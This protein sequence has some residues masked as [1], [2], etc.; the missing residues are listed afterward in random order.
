[1][2]GKSVF[3]YS[4]GG[5]LISIENA[6]DIRLTGLALE[7]EAKPMDGG[8]LVVAEQVKGFDLSDCSIRRSEDG[9]VLREVSGRITDCEF[10]GHLR[11]G[12]TRGARDLR[13]RQE[14]RR[15]SNPNRE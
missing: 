15:I 8:A 10:D 4:G 5:A 12:P 14:P 3:R 7:G 6:S 2:S 11:Y 1:M 9:I 13:D